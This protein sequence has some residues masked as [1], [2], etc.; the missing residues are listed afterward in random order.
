MCQI[1][2]FSKNEDNTL[3]NSDTT[4]EEQPA[5]TTSTD[6]SQPTVEIT[7]EGTS[8]TLIDEGVSQK[9]QTQE[10]NSVH[11]PGISDETG[12]VAQ[13]LKDIIPS[14]RISKAPLSES[15]EKPLYSINI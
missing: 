14:L 3:P 2:H 4:N 5:Q 6:Q 10:I 7:N 8:K 15:G 9:G 11:D 12:T 1:S 13:E